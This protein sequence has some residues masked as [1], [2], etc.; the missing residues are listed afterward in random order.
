MKNYIDPVEKEILSVKHLKLNKKLRVP[1]V[2][3]H[4]KN[5]YN[6]YLMNQELQLRTAHGAP[7]P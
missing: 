1:I 3:D 6:S 4:M 7:I 5:Y 2:K